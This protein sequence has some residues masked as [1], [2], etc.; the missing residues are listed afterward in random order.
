[1]RLVLPKSFP[2]HGHGFGRLHERDQ[3]KKREK[4]VLRARQH[5]KCALCERQMLSTQKIEVLHIISKF[6]GG[7]L[8]DISP[9][10]PEAQHP[11]A[12]LGHRICNRNM[13]WELGLWQSQIALYYGFDLIGINHEK[14]EQ[15]ARQVWVQTALRPKLYPFWLFKST[16]E[17]VFLSDGWF[18]E[19]AYF[20]QQIETYQP[21]IEQD[22]GALTP[23][24]LGR[25]RF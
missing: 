14:V 18:D 8:Y 2:T 13:G 3:L 9:R 22:D 6:K 1:M 10:F 21:F 25:S 15:K 17:P 11:N 23:I 24:G 4:E 12:C 5:N 7:Q 20:K 16:G 19:Q